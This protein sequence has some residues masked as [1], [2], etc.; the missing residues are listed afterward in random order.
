MPARWWCRWAAV[1][2]ALTVG[3]GPI[4]AQESPQA[5]PDS[6]PPRPP[7]IPADSIPDHARA[8]ATILNGLRTRLPSDSALARLDSA[9]DVIEQQYAEQTGRTAP[10]RLA[11]M[12]CDELV[13]LQAALGPSRA[14]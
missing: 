7:P 6:A 13:D 10:G 1:L 3:A 4:G 12:F 8:A 5:A 2:A 9:F 14:A 11:A